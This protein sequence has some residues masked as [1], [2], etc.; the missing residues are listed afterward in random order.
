MTES[1]QTRQL[2]KEIRNLLPKAVV[3]KHTDSMTGGLP[4]FSV[5]YSG[6]TVWVEAKALALNQRSLVSA[7]KDRGNWGVRVVPKRDVP[8]RQWENL[9]RMGNGYLLFY[10]DG[11]AALTHVS[12]FRLDINE[13][14]LK[15]NNIKIVARMIAAMVKKKEEE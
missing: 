15:L 11:R 9:R 6:S 4:D 8:A 3:T 5:T 13:M 14:I 12:G 1:E 2:I 10:A 7:N